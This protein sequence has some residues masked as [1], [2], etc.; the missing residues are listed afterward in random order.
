MERFNSTDTLKTHQAEC[1]KNSDLKNDPSA[2]H[3]L[4]SD[5]V[6][7]NV[8][9]LIKASEKLP[10]MNIPLAELN[11]VLND[12]CWDDISGKKLKPREVI[13]LIGNLPETDEQW[14]QLEL[15]YPNL[16]EHLRRIKQANDSSSI[17]VASID[18]ELIVIDG[19]HRLAR[20]FLE[21]KGDVRVKKFDK[22]PTNTATKINEA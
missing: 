16:S 19:L 8:G 6:K 5:G 15:A 21:N 14:Q 18:S 11:H 13:D 1:Q 2:D 22:L 12:E 10:L 7:Y 20:A 3:W 17:L 4:I 9:F